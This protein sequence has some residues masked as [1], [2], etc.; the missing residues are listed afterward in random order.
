[1]PELRIPAPFDFQAV[2]CDSAAWYKLLCW[3]RRAGKSRLALRSANLGHGPMHGGEPLHKGLIH[4]FD[5]IWVARSLKQAKSIWSEEVKPR[6]RDA[7]GYMNDTDLIAQVYGCGRL[8]VC[9]QDPDSINNARGMGATVG[10]VICDEVAHWHDAEGVWKEVLLPLLLDNDGWAMFTSTPSLVPSWFN[11]Q[12]D[13]CAAGDLNERWGLWE[14]TAQD[15]PI[16][17]PD[18]FRALVD[19]YSPADPRLQ[20]EVFGKRVLG[21][22]GLAFPEW[23]RRVHIL[24]PDTPVPDHWR[25]VAGM[26]YGYSN[27]TVCTLFACGEDNETW[28]M[29]EYV[30]QEKEPTELGQALGIGFMTIGIP[31]WI[32]ADENMW[33]A[34]PTIPEKVQEGLDAVLGFTKVPLIAAPKG[35]G[36]RHMRKVLM[37]QALRWKPGANGII[38]P[39]GMPQLRIHPRCSYITRTLPRL[40]KDPK[41]SE[42]VWKEHPDTHGYDAIGYMMQTRAP[43]AGMRPHVI[44][45]NVHPGFRADGT[46]RDRE[47][48]PATEADDMRLM[49]AQQGVGT[50]RYGRR[51]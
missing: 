32:G 10:G 36:S 28:L 11:E 13:R 14:A 7:G 23:D 26:D 47:R 12:C 21:G 18:A 38:V 3:G 29:W 25:W 20:S 19:E 2:A 33:H 42:D 1:M 41:D 39:W 50:S 45:E 48:T 49:F 6:F 8:I 34:G 51:R 5:V 30:C 17:S 4:N 43:K 22:P 44:P 9:S 37:H 46:R 27:P 40:P 31:E 16:I 35:P 15:N 24:P